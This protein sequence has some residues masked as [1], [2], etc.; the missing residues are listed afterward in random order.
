MCEGL[1]L[2]SKVTVTNQ[3]TVHPEGFTVQPVQNQKAAGCEGKGKDLFVRWCSETWLLGGNGPP[4][5]WPAAKT[6]VLRRPPNRGA[7]KIQAQSGQGHES[8]CGPSQQ[9]VV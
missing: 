7:K 2:E 6:K 9:T 3:L 5:W 4:R 8:E 1:E